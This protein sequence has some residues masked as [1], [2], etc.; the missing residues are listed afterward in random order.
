MLY[1]EAVGDEEVSVLA[2]TLMELLAIKFRVFI[3]AGMRSLVNL[4]KRVQ[5]NIGRLT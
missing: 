1:I 5:G 4:P 3:E 2:V